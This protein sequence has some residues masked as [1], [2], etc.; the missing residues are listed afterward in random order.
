[1][2]RPHPVTA[3]DCTQLLGGR[4]NAVRYATA[5]ID[6]RHR[7]ISI[8]VAMNYRMPSLA[9]R[10]LGQSR[11]VAADRF[12]HYTRLA[13]L[14]L[15]KY[16]SRTIT[17]NGADYD[18]TV[19]ARTA[20]DGLPLILA[21]TGSP[22]LG[23]LS[24]RSSNPYPLLR[25]NL[26][27]EPHHEGDADA[28]F[29]MTAAHE[30]GHAFLTSAFGIHWSWGHGGTSSIFGRMAAGAP[31]YP[32]SGEIALMTYY[33]SNPTATIYRQDILRRTIASENDVKT[34]LYIAGRE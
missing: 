14:G 22:L 18:V 26:Y 16:W 10:V 7:S 30:I 2:F 3:F 5:S 13:D 28:M 32:T 20:A 33:R 8:Q 23:P 6:D 11:R 31:P 24:S 15:G 21:H 27:Y 4:A 34:L 25:G 29:A 19:T 17:L 1:M 12:A 9:A